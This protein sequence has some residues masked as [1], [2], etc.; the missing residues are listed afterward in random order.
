MKTREFIGEAFEELS[1]EEM[2]MVQGSGDVDSEAN[3]VSVVGPI[4]ATVSPVLVTFFAK[5]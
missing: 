5:C 4:T 3:V 2:K 1:V